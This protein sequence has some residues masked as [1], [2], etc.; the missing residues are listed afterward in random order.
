SLVLVVHRSCRTASLLLS[1]ACVLV[2]PG[3][4]RIATP[5]GSLRMF[6]SFRVAQASLAAELDLFSLKSTLQVLHLSF[7]PVLPCLKA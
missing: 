7:H 4:A 2:S 6:P 5:S 1:S 3:A